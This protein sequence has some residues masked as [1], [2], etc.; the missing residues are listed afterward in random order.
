MCIPPSNSRTLDTINDEYSFGRGTVLKSVDAGQTWTDAGRPDGVASDAAQLA[1][2]PLDPNT[3]FVT[4]WKGLFETTTAGANR[5][6]LF[7]PPPA[8]QTRA[9]LS[10]NLASATLCAGAPFTE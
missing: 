3:V 8:R 2:S 6:L 9:S 5:Q 1:I 7:A 10:L 4:T